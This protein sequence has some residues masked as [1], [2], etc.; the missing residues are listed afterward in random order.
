MADYQSKYTGEQIDEAIG[1]ALEGGGGEV[2]FYPKVITLYGYDSLAQGETVI[3]ERGIDV[4]TYAIL[5]PQ[6]NETYG[7]RVLAKCVLAEVESFEITVNKTYEYRTGELPQAGATF[8]IYNEVGWANIGDCIAVHC[9]YYSGTP[10]FGWV[11]AKV[12]DIQSDGA[13]YYMEVLRELPIDYDGTLGTITLKQ[14]V[15][16]FEVIT[17]LDEVVY[18]PYKRYLHQFQLN[19]MTT[20]ET[21]GEQI[22]VKLA[23]NYLLERSEAITLGEMETC[24]FGKCPLSGYVIEKKL[25][26]TGT[27]QTAESY[28]CLG[29]LRVTPATDYHLYY[30]DFASSTYANVQDFAIRI[31][32]KSDDLIDMVTPL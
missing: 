15:S 20:D 6:N 21:T 11:L 14:G 31:D 7:K 19:T 12:T 1:K 4:D 17:V 25:D 24:L 3:L 13:K 18:S 2:K 26:G 10:D 22:G 9:L 29:F 23:V 8:N 5:Q 30:F 28:Y 27:V 16:T 32:I